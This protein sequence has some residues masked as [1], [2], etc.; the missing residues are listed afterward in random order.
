[1]KDLLSVGGIVIIG[2]TN[3]GCACPSLAVRD[4]Q[5]PSS[6][7]LVPSVAEGNAWAN[8]DEHWL[9]GYRELETL[10]TIFQKAVA[11]LSCHKIVFVQCLVCVLS[12]RVNARSQGWIMTDELIDYYIYLK[13]IRERQ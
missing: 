7:R 11:Y 1:V 12:M 8:A 3:S 4:A 10:R 2:E 5:D 6:C 13:N 9:L